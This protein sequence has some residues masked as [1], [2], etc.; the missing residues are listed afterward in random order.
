MNVSAKLFVLV[1]VL[2][3]LTATFFLFFSSSQKDASEIIN[4][5]PH[6]KK[7]IALGDSLV[8][9]TGDPEGGG[10][11]SDL[12]SLLGTPILNA[13]NPG[14]TSA[15]GLRR[16]NDVLSANPDIVILL[17]GGNDA[18]QQVPKNE[19]RENLATI[20]TT[21]QSEGVVVILLGVQGGLFG[22]PYDEMYENLAEKYGTLYVPNVLEG[23]LTDPKLMAG[24]V[25]PNGKGYEIIAERVK[26]K[27][28]RLL[29]AA[30]R[31]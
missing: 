5:P 14:E 27:L 23:I 17:F 18:I 31:G 26:P 6:G 11:V 24:T 4:F 8:Y 7:V 19:T 13:G 30:E 12:T 2:A 20:I 15:D 3:L 29:V 9:G 28:K 25:H 10:F 22:D 21:L 16:V 1:T